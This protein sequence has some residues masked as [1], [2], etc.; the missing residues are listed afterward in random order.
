MK[1][2]PP[3]Y[4]DWTWLRRLHQCENNPFDTG[5]SL[6]GFETVTS[7]ATA[8]LGGGPGEGPRV[9]VTVWLPPSARPPTRRAYRQ[10]ERMTA[11]SSARI[12]INLLALLAEPYIL[13]IF[14]IFFSS[15]IKNEN[16]LQL[17]DRRFR[18]N[19][20][21]QAVCDTPIARITRCASS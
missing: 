20:S 8:W 9:H 15:T 7:A 11:D 1:R 21:S 16:T 5:G 14:I 10:T 2:R 13:C 4:G 19:S 6:C 18:R 12:K 3:A 17:W